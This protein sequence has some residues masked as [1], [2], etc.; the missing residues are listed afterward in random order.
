M[1]HTIHR[2]NAERLA[3]RE[4]YTFIQRWVTPAQAQSIAALELPGV[5][6][7]EEPRR[8]YPYGD[9]AGRLIGFADIDG[10]GVRGIE[11]QE[12][13]F[14]RGR[15]YTERI[16]RDARGQ[17]MSRPGQRSETRGGDIALTIDTGLQAHAEAAL[18]QAIEK[19]GA[20]GGT[21]LAPSAPKGNV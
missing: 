1:Y 19:S 4:N 21:V 8:A 18:Q 10:Q 13:H 6:I 15:Q 7:A 5:G 16:T 2:R 12:E 9:L 11:Q 14:L 20:E 17:T 3:N